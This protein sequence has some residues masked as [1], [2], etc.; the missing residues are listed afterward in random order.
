MQSF[1][2][3]FRFMRPYW[4]WATLAPLFM[5]LEVALDLIHPRLIQ[6]IIDEGIGCLDLGLVVN[7]S[8]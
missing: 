7:T 5:V 2:R 6:R 8:A 3:L 1:R 4:K